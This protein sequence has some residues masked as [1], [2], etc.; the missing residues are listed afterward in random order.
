MDAADW[1]D[2]CCWRQL[3]K[4]GWGT[5]R[6]LNPVTLVIPKG[7]ALIF[8]TWL[9]HAGAEWKAGD[10]CGYN[11]MHFYFTKYAISS[12]S[13]VFMQD[14]AGQKP[15]EEGRS[16]SPALHFLPLPTKDWKAA[17]ARVL[18]KWVAVETAE[19]VSGL[20]DRAKR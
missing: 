1:W 18:P 14:R 13:S 5:E 17:G 15:E 2:Y 4:E 3:Q 16:F 11:R 19:R 7:H 8:S 20:R 9:L 10:T 6:C 12:M